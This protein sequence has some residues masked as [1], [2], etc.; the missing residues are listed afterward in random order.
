MTGRLRDLAIALLLGCVG[1][2][3]G[4]QPPRSFSLGQTGISVDAPPGYELDYSDADADSPEL[5]FAHPTNSSGARPDLPELALAY[6]DTGDAPAE[7]IHAGLANRKQEFI[8]APRRRLLGSVESIELAGT[9]D[10]VSDFASGG[11]S[12][13]AVVLHMF[14]FSF[15]GSLYSCSLLCHLPQYAVERVDVERFC[16]SIRL[17]NM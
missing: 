12:L 6:V 4:P 5:S 9:G 13:Q 17:P 11:S 2:V 1:E 10:M 3:P 15:R 14:L 16:L 7:Y 8:V